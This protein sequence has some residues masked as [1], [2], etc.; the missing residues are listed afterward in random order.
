MQ[1]NY[2]KIF[3]LNIELDHDQIAVEA[4]FC[5]CFLN[6]ISILFTYFALFMSLPLSPRHYLEVVILLDCFLLS[7][8]TD[9]DDDDNTC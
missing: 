1:Y 7:R 5:Y 3:I 2:V 6:K 9:D 8:Q 4:S